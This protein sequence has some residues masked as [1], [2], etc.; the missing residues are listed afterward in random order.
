MKKLVLLALTALVTIGSAFSSLAEENGEEQLLVGAAVRVVTPTKE[1][2]MLPVPGIG[3]DAGD[4]VDV[5]EDLHT[6]VIAFQ[7]GDN[8]ALLVCTE[9][10]K[11][12][13]GW[14]FAEELSE[15]TGVPVEGIF[16]TTTHSHSAPEVKSEISLE[17]EEGEEVDNATKWARYTLE[18]MKDAADEALANLQPVTVEIGYGESYINVNRNRTYVNRIDGTTERT[19]GYNPTGFSDKTLTVVSFNDME[20][21][22]VA[23]IVN[24]PMHGVTMIAN[25]YFDGETGIHPDVPG[26]VSLL[27]EEEY[28][29]SVAVW[30]SGA[31]GDQN[32]M[33]SNQVMYPDP[34]TGEAVTEYTGDIK[35]MEYLGNI[36]YS[37]I[38]N[39]IDNMEPVDASSVSFA[40]GV[41]TIPNEEGAETEEFALDLKILRIGDIV[42]AGSPGELWASI[43]AYMKDNSLLEN[44]IVVNHTWTQ[45]DAYTGYICDDDGRIN[46]GYST[47][48][49]QYKTGYI[50]DALTDLMNSL[51]EETNE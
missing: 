5:I 4:M 6:R 7:S 43:G 46:G 24:Y 49:L 42:F 37:D 1:N 8:T 39:V 3:R 28:E 36:H 40:E 27:L 29:G 25:T 50:N 45:K 22:P 14:Q 9:T 51:I 26:Y 13:V 20:G 18:Q 34:K 2:G 19:L 30:T 38:L 12:P 17:P 32:P 44:T 23:Y 41:T 33:V 21:N 35:I 31:A 16:Y 48:K 10:G 15:Y 11:G 47:D